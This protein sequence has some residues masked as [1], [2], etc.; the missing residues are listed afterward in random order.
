MDLGD[1]RI[2]R[3]AGGARRAALWDAVAMTEGPNITFAATAPSLATPSGRALLG[4]ELTHMAQQEAHGI[5]AVQRQAGAGALGVDPAFARIRARLNPADPTQAPDVA[6]ALNELNGRRMSQLLDWLHRLG[7]TAP[8]RQLADPLGGPRLHLA[9]ELVAEA[10]SMTPATD[11][12]LAGLVQ[13]A[14]TPQDPTGGLPNDQRQEVVSFMDTHAVAAPLLRAALV[15]AC[16]LTEPQFCATYG[17]WLDKLPLPAPAPDLTF[18]DVTS[19]LPSDLK[20]VISGAIG[21]NGALPD[22]ADVAFILRDFYLRKKKQTFGFKAGGR[23]F[24]LGSPSPREVRTCMRLTTSATFRS[25]NLLNFYRQGSTPIHNLK[26]LL[27]AGLH[28]GDVFVWTR[29]P[30]VRGNFQGHAQ[31]VQA[32]MRPTPTSGGRIVFAQ[33]SMRGV[34]LGQL[35]AETRTFTGLTG[36]ADGD[37]P[38]QVRN[39]EESFFGAGQWKGP[40]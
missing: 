14:G 30:S 4:H 17:D 32:I 40:R 34:G 27:D 13:A 36:K 19:G 26:H 5:R 39:N 16:R 10:G 21:P 12:M 1:A 33:G 22:C 37:A 38:I 8:M 7:V 35:Q 9:V 24:V 11:Q 6:G 29:L 2:R 28:S 25:R 18:E 15:P 3:D 20:N 31:T 23:Q